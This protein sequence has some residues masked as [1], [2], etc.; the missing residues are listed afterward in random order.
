MEGLHAV[1]AKLAAVSAK[2]IPSLVLLAPADNRQVKVS[3]RSLREA[4]DCITS[5]TSSTF[6]P[7]LPYLT[8]VEL[9][10]PAWAHLETTVHTPTPY[11]YVTSR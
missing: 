6:E 5:T 7:H 8:A 10:L 2:N 1:V 9:T 4:V 11:Y 3:L